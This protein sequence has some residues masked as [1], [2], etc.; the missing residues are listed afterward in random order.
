MYGGYFSFDSSRTTGLTRKSV[1]C[2]ACCICHCS[3]WFWFRQDHGFD[4][5]YVSHQLPVYLKY[6]VCLKLL[7]Q[8][9]H[10]ESVPDILQLGTDFSWCVP[11]RRIENAWFLLAITASQ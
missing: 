4:P 11:L 1:D 3:A 9:V 5:P 2:V 6:S 8:L 7:A 10:G